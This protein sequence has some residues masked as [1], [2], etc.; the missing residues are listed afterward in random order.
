MDFR[1]VNI[2]GGGFLLQCAQGAV[3]MPCTLRLLRVVF[4][5][6]GYI[7]GGFAAAVARSLLGM[8]KQPNDLYSNTRR[9]LGMPRSHPTHMYQNAGC[10]D[11]DVWFPDQVSL[12]GF[13]Q[14]ERVKSLSD[15]PRIG[16]QTTKTGVYEFIIDGDARIQVITRYLRPMV[17]QLQGFDIYN[18]ML[19]MTD[20]QLLVPP[21]WEWLEQQRMIHVTTWSSP[22]TVNRVMKYFYRKGYQ[23]LTPAAANG[24]YDAVMAAIEFYKSG[25]MPKELSDGNKA[26]ILA[27][28]SGKGAQA[29]FQKIMP[30]LPTE[31][32]LQLSAF[33]RAEPTY[34]LAM[35]ELHKR[36]PPR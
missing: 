3:L 22:W 31:K 33:F 6:S 32:L 30:A 15:D 34:D 24:F 16:R 17:E 5:H 19:A 2:E 27:R 25:D 8:G 4:D 23:H 21:E 36:M 13:M 28:G 1:R 35:Q 7:A 11:I 10:G 18:S 29:V 26:I 9:H 12:D 14:D 20:D